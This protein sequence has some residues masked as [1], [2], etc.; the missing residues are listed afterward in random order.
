MRCFDWR[1]FFLSCILGLTTNS[2]FLFYFWNKPSWAS[3]V[4]LD[5][6]CPQQQF[7][8]YLTTLKNTVSVL[9]IPEEKYD[10]GIRR[11]AKERGAALLALSFCGA[12]AVPI[13]RDELRRKNGYFATALTSIEHIGPEAEA[14]TPEIVKF[15]Y[16]VLDE[17][18]SNNN[19]ETWDQRDFWHKGWSLA[20]YLKTLHAIAKDESI[21]VF[22]LLKRLEREKDDEKK[23]WI[24]ATLDALG[25]R[26]VAFFTISN[27][28]KKS[29]KLREEATEALANMSASTNNA[30]SLIK[31][32]Q[33]EEPCVSGRAALAFGRSGSSDI[34]A[35]PYL[36]KTV[37]TS[38]DSKVK[39]NAALS[40]ISIGLN[41]DR[42]AISK[43]LTQDVI[44]AIMRDPYSNGSDNF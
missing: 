6:R 4:P 34:N 19:D 14:A 7:N 18:G 30:S 39:Y 3:Y 25:A 27:L 22:D 35:I 41:A 43:A 21:I 44:S 26:S 12:K 31:L 42:S 38:R 5:R 1:S 24:A 17:P 40:L 15:I 9:D 16:D 37:M 32:L 13:L 20:R 29:Q 28:I 8:Q 36:Q 23:I 33:D 10:D 2:I 11:L